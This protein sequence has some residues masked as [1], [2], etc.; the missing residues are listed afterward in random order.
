MVVVASLAALLASINHVL[1]SPGQLPLATHPSRYFDIQ[2]HRG[3]RGNVVE[4]LLPAF[5]W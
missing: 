5:A 1:A 4:N 2:A 3:G